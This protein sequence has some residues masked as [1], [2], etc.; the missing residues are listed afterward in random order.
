M[1]RARPHDQTSGLVVVTADE[2][3]DLWVQAEDAF[4]AAGPS[5]TCTAT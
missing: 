4:R 1:S 3:P 2:R 5:T